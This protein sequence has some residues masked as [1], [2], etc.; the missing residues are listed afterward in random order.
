MSAWRLD[1]KYRGELVW[2]VD[3]HSGRDDREPRIKFDHKRTD[4]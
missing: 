3:W 2:T 4:P 1:L